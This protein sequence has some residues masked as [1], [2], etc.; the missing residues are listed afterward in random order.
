MRTLIT[1]LLLAF[2]WAVSAQ[3]IT[4]SGN[5]TDPDNVPLE[6]ATVYISSAKDSTLINYTI[7]DNK[8]GW[9]LKTRAFDAPVYLK[10]S[11]VGFTTHRQ[12]IDKITSD[13]D[14]GTIQMQ[15]KGT[16]LNEVVIEGEVPP[17]RIK[18]DTLEFDAASFNVREDAN[19]QELLKQLPGVE[20]DETG[21]ITV[22]GKEVSQ[23]LV[24]GK[25]FFDK[26]GKIALQNLPAEII[27]KIQ[28]SDTKT[29]EEEMT[30]QKSTGN[31]ASIN[32][33]IDEEKNK[34]IFGRATVGFGT[35]GVYEHSMLA[36]YFKGERKIS[37][38]AST[39][40]INSTGFSMD[41]I[42][43]NMS[44]G[45]NT[46]AW[47]DGKSF[48]INGMQFG[49]GQGITRTDIGGAYYADK[50]AKGFE[51]AV[52]YF[53]TGTDSKND[54]ESKVTT[55][56]PK[57][58]ETDADQSYV[59]ESTG[60][61]HQDRYGHYV[62]TQFEIKA[63]S[64]FTIYAEPKF[65]K[66]HNYTK[67]EASSSTYRLASGE[68]LND[69]NGVNSSENN[70]TGFSNTLVATKKFNAK[71]G[72]FLS[73]DLENNNQKGDNY[74][75]NNT[76]TNTYDYAGGTPVVTTENR[77]QIRR[78][79]TSKDIYHFSVSYGEPVTDSSNVY[80]QGEVWRETESENRRGYNF[81]QGTDNYSDYNDAL[82][83]YLSAKT[84]RAKPALGYNFTKS[85]MYFNIEA[86]TFFIDYA[87]NG[88]YLGNGL[89]AKRNEVIPN[90][91]MYLNYNFTKTRSFSISYDYNFT[92]PQASQILPVADVLNPLTTIIGNSDLDF[93]KTH[94]LW[95]NLYDYNWSEKI[96][97]NIYAGGTYYQNNISTSTLIDENARTTVSYF[98]VNDTYQY[99]L[100]GQ[101]GKTFKREAHSLNASVGMY[102]ESG[103][104]K[105]R[106]NEQLFTSLSYSTE[107]W[108]GL[109]Y[110]YGEL[111]TINPRYRIE[112]NQTDYDNYVISSAKS[113]IH[114]LSLATTSRWPKHVVWG[115]DLTYN[116]NSQQA[117]FRKS[118][119]LL[120]TSL[121]Y[122]FLKDKF[123]F[124]VK[125]YDLLNQN[126]GASRSLTPTGISEQLN[127]VLKR[128]VMFS[129]SVKLDKFAGKKEEQK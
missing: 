28:V 129:L 122:N 35:S 79:D 20:I 57:E 108:V 26:D 50:W 124:K 47:S 89:S 83:G 59:T 6:A 69:N 102:I 107:P 12:L 106:Q 70:T 39:N 9:Q 51:G 56:V 1:V 94:N 105:G 113:T 46:S 55:F 63:D 53:Y 76:I 31:E 4:L 125:V 115:N 74:N 58:T 17:I 75:L 16:N 65:Q 38:L 67:N 14:F 54:T 119:Y 41:E 33:T 77:N 86:G 80:F 32:I 84:N 44:G 81:N 24:N 66:G 34:G 23:I 21:K 104:N 85:K 127:T 109:T 27:N 88:S 112:F 48:N 100:G 71:K 93:V 96:G 49:G 103:L 60:K 10:V 7:T 128:Y 36:N 18:K 30:G 8:G 82:S 37:V 13:T 123:T 101:Y 5:V 19:V 87:A 45:R 110:S 114:R 29:K 3:N 111:L 22:N 78:T 64:T 25:P 91:E 11:Y 98:N 43:D 72:R 42:F 118:Y 62:N 117:S 61:N 126:L 121:G 92:A 2:S 95:I 120:N 52:N 99:W 97:Y 68:V 116:Y 15:D 73:F 40:N 90:V